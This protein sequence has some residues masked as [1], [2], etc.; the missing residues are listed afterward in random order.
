MNLHPFIPAKLAEAIAKADGG[1]GREIEALFPLADQ[2]H[3]RIK[4]GKSL[5]EI[6][7]VF[8]VSPMA[9]SVLVEN[10]S[11]GKR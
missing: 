7:R 4:A 3:A 2:I 8:C 6:A 1:V 9:V 11:E 5:E 10:T